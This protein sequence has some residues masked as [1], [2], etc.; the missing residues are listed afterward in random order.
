MDEHDKRFLTFAAELSVR[1]GG[2]IDVMFDERSY[3][4][5]WRSFLEA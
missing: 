1:M 5:N 4:G 2:R 3:S